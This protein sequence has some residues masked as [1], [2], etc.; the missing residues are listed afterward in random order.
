MGHPAA[1]LFGNCSLIHY[2]SVL[3]DQLKQSN[4]QETMHQSM[5]H[6]QLISST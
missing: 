5:A 4:Q 6:I 3:Q 2:R 1:L